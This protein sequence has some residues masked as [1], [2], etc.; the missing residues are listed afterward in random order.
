[1]VLSLK[2]S[3]WIVFLVFIFLIRA[4]F[5][6]HPI[7]HHLTAPTELSEE[8]K[9]HITQFSPAD[10]SSI[11][12]SFVQCSSQ[13]SVLTHPQLVSLQPMIMS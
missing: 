12:L 10:N 9:L 4:T 1:M 2:F 13:H 8:Y 11:S 7:L 6:E 3:D 5:S